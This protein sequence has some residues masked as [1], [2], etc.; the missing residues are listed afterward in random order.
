M[1]SISGGGKVLKPIVILK[2]LQNLRELAEY[3][4][5]CFFATSATGWMTKDIWI[6]YALV[7]SAQISQ[8]RL[9]LPPELRDH[10]MLLVIDG[11]KTRISVVAA[12]I[13][14]LNG[15]DVLTLPAHTSHLL[16]M[17]DVACYPAVKAAFKKELDKQMDMIA[18]AEPGR[19][20]QAMRT[21]LVESFINGLQRGAT[22]RNIL[23][24]F[25]KSG[26]SPLDPMEPLLSPFAVEPQQDGVYQ[27]VNTGAEINEMVLTWPSGL[28]KLARIEHGRD[29]QPM[30]EEINYRLVWESLSRKTVVQ[31]RPISRPPPFFIRLPG[32]PALIREVHV[33]ELDP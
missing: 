6:Y 32:D 3:E 15:I 19:K 20:I 2:S 24:G 16:Q 10:D 26:I 31:G 7:F 25:R 23:A 4:D 28:N 5:H 14:M 8:Y 1:V 12:V 11:H 9:T 21:A 33:D 13:F 30:D 27:T 17:L 29:F 22:P 18:R